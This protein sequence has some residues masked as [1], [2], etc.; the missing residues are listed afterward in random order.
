ME[1][2][3]SGGWELLSTPFEGL[4]GFAPMPEYPEYSADFFDGKH[5][6]LR[7]SSPVT[8]PSVCR[9]SF[10]NF[11]QANYPFVFSKFRCGFRIQ[12]KSPGFRVQGL[13]LGLQHCDMQGGGEREDK[14][15]PRLPQ[16]L[17]Q[18]LPGQLPLCVLQVQGR[19]QDFLIPVAMVQDC[20]PTRP[21]TS[22]CPPTHGVSRAEGCLI[23]RGGSARAAAL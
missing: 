10:R 18:H 12:A 1:Q 4:K 3:K 21:A 22:S 11:Y 9:D 8:H 2:L 14:E 5:C 13:N 19:L 17:P 7:G 16:Q 15:R 20:C 23:E 6:V